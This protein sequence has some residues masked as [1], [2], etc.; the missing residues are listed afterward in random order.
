MDNAKIHFAKAIQPAL[1]LLCAVHRVNLVFL[2][3]YSPELNPAELVFAQV[4]HYLRH[5]RDEKARFWQELIRAFGQVTKDNVRKYVL[6][7]LK[8]KK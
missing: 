3:T 6:H 1:K 2:P 8:L 4:K 5:S 7:C